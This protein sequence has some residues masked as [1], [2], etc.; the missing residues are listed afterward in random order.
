MDAI[1][2]STSVGGKKHQWTALEDSKLVECLLDITNSGK[3]KANNGTFK[4]GYLQQLEK[5]LNEKIPRCGLKAQPH[6]DS[7]IKILKKQFHAISEM[8]G[9][10]GGRFEW[11]AEDKCIVAD[12]NVY[13]EWVKSHPTAKGLRYRSFPY[14]DELG[15]VFGKDRA[16]GQGAMG[17]SD[18]VEESA[19]EIRNDQGTDKKIRND[20][21]IDK[22]TR[23]DQDNDVDPLNHFDDLDGA[24]SVSHASTQSALSQSGK[25]SKRSRSEDALI[26]VL[27]KTVKQFGKMH[28]ASGETINKIANCF[29]YEADGAARRMRVFDELKKVNGLTNSQRVRVGHLLVQNQANTDYFFTL[30]DEFKLEFLQQ[31]LG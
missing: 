5:L 12:K 2:P 27:T 19:K 29:Q 14:Y 24:A 11:N 21:D 3:W 13:E 15:V 8:L 25:K 30:D 6:I 10:C 31:L 22:E 17:F 9:H 1:D 16:T 28:A 26:D 18:M 23:N 20:Q 4:H 7:R